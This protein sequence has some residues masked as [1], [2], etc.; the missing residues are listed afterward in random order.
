MQETGTACYSG[1]KVDNILLSPL[2]KGIFNI[3]HQ[4]QFQ[5]Q[6]NEGFNIKMTL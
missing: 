5:Y 1:N 4:G 2:K 3:S 6:I